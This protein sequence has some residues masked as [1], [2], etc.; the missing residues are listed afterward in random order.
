VVDVRTGNVVWAREPY[1]PG[2]KIDR[3]KAMTMKLQAFISFEW[4]DA[5]MTVELVQDL[6]Q[7]LRN[8]IQAG[9]RQMNVAYEAKYMQ[10]RMVKVWH[11][12][13]GTGTD[14]I[15]RVARPA[16][17]ALAR[18]SRRLNPNAR[19]TTGPTKRQ[20][21]AQEGKR[22]M[23]RQIKFVAIAV[24]WFD[25]VQGKACHSVHV[26]RCSDGK[27]ICCRDYGDL[28]IPTT[29]RTMAEEKWIPARYRQ[30]VYRYEREEGY[31]VFWHVQQGIKSDCLANGEEPGSKRKA[32]D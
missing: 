17:A 10:W 21:K 30:D 23:E 1:K 29:I 13:D 18:P 28:Y 8:S 12:E 20:S 7:E 25:C 6:Y 9:T 32:R 27:T 4:V 26:T 19:K 3:W 31:P 24:T 11:G 16:F 22:T 2:K 14:N 15:G 5:D